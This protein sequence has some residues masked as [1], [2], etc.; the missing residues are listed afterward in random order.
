MIIDIINIVGT[1][2]GFLVTVTLLVVCVDNRRT[3]RRR[4]KDADEHVVVWD[5]VSE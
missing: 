2:F 1:A 4:P 3:G 5:G